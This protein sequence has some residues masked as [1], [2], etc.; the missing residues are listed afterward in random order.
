MVPRRGPK[1]L[2][3]SRYKVPQKLQAITTSTQISDYLKDVYT[4]F[5]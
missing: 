2:T 1:A 4:K 5:N 3:E